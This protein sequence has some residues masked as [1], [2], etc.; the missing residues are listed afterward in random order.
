MERVFRDKWLAQ[1]EA[2]DKQRN[3]WLDKSDEYD[4][5]GRTK[6]A[7]RA[8]EK[9]SDIE[10]QMTGMLIALRIFGYTVVTQRAFNGENKYV[11]VEWKGD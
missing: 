2:L 4:E 8:D 11:V 9:A 5:K 7:H 10:S 1:Y 6:S 3:F